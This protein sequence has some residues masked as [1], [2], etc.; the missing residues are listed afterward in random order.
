MKRSLMPYLAIATGVSVAMAQALHSNS[1]G[2]AV[3]LAI[4]ILLTF[5]SREAH[6]KWWR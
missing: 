3:G 4:F 1:V 5:G 6:C 2:L